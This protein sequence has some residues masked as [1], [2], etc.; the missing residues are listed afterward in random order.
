MRVLIVKLGSIGDIIHT[1]PS[2]SAMRRALPNAEISWVVEE[3]SAE[4]LRGNPLIDN[5]IE[6]DTRSL[7]GGKIIEEIFLDTGRQIRK[8][9]EYTF[10]VAIDFQGLLKSAVIARLSGAP[11]RW[12][13]ARESLREPAGRYFLTDTVAVPKHVHVIRKNLALLA[14]ALGIEM[15][16]T[17]LDFPIA[18][19]DENRAE[20]DAVARQTDGDFAILNP[21]GGWVTKLWPAENFGTLADR[22]WLEHRLTSVVTT[23]PNEDGLA[24]R[25]TEKSTSG[26]LVNAKL[27][28]KGFYEL[29]KLAKLYVG[30]DTGPTHLAVAAGTPVVGLFGPTEWWRNGSLNPDDICIERNDIACRVDCHRRTCGKW[31][32]M[33][34]GVDVVLDA[35]GKSLATNTSLR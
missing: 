34:I 25:A 5:L 4:I 15:A 29:A 23:G 14:G 18:T 28:L 1:L 30:G 17:D 13:F 7:R 10:D 21:G 19:N 20:A 24:E 22:L 16:D 8:L 32:C 2:L 3:R 9:R 31:I 33:D 27:S 26:K 6:V 35:V 11:R 12:G